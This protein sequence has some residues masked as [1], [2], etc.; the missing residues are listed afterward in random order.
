MKQIQLDGRFYISWE[1]P[2][3]DDAKKHLKEAEESL[4]G[5]SMHEVA[6]CENY[7]EGEEVNHFDLTTGER[8]V[9]LPVQEPS[10]EE[11]WEQELVGLKVR[12]T[13]LD[14][15]SD[16]SVRAMLCKTDTPSDRA[17]LQGIEADIQ[18]KRS[19]IRELGSLLKPK[20]ALSGK[21]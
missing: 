6:F 18:V 10:K 9:A 5:F 1:G 14:R 3:P 16:R 17:Y 20:E 15:A 21:S 8:I 7:P 19:R 12:C 4:N 2:A 11:L 13:E